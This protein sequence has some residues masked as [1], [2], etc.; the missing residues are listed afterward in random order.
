MGHPEHLTH[1]I[2]IKTHEAHRKL[3]Q[4]L[5]LQVLDLMHRTIRQY[6]QEILLQNQEQIPIFLHQEAALLVVA[7][8]VAEVVVLAVAAVEAVEVNT[9][10]FDLIYT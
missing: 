1:E 4:I 6:L 7:L 9:H 5:D 3:I 10:E 2:Q 8:E